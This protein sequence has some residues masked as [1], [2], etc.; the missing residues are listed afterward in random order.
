[1]NVNVKHNIGDIIFLKTDLEQKPRIVYGYT[2]YLASLLYK[3]SQGDIVSE[4]YDFE[5]STEVNLLYK[6]DMSKPYEN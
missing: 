5:I 4:H 1:M 6:L 2:V 3:V